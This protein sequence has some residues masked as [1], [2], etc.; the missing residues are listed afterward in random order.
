MPSDWTAYYHA[1]RK[2]AHLL[3]WQGYVAARPSI[4]GALQEPDITGLIADAIDE[5]LDSPDAD[6]RFDR[7]EVHEEKPLTTE[8]RLGKRRRRTDILIKSNLHRPRH[9]YIFEAKKIEGLPSI[10]SGYLGTEGILRF[11]VGEYGSSSSDAAMVGYVIKSTVQQLKG[12]IREELTKQR[13]TLNY[14]GN[15]KNETVNSDLEID[16]TCHMRTEKDEIR[17][18]HIILDCC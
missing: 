2:D 13:I 14:I 7:Y 3:L 11:I 18:S 15:I 17:I 9:K 4:N 8:D 5:F 10:R 6:E 12:V 16:V 1:F